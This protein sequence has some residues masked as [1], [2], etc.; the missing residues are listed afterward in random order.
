[1]RYVYMFEE[2]RKERTREKERGIV[3]KNEE[4]KVRARVYVTERKSEERERGE[5]RRENTR[6]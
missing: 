6:E 1:M 3:E 4:E 5:E 2:K